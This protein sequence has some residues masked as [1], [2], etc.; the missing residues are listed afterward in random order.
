MKK[1]QEKETKIIVTAIGAY[2]TRVRSYLATISLN[3]ITRQAIQIFK[4]NAQ[5][6][7]LNVT[8]YN[9]AVADFN[10]RHGLLLLKRGAEQTQENA[11]DYNYINFPYLN[12]QGMKKAMD[13]YRK[14]VYQYNIEVTKQNKEI[15]KYNTTVVA[16][17]S[18]E[19][20]DNELKKITALQENPKGL[21]PREYNKAVA[22]LNTELQVNYIP[23]KRIQKVK[24]TSELV[25]NVLLGFYISQLQTRNNYLQGLGKSTRVHKNNVPKLKIDNRKLANH[26]ISGIPRLDLCKKTAQNHIKRL[27]EAGILINYEY[28]NQY[29]PITVHFNTAIVQILEGKFPKKQHPQNQ[30]FTTKCEKDLHDN[31]DSSIYLKRKE[32]KD[33][34]NFIVGDKCGSTTEA[35]VCPADGYKNTSRISTT[36]STG[37]QKDKNTMRKLLPDFLQTASEKNGTNAVLTRNFLAKITDD[38][39]LAKELTAGK[40]NQYTVLSYHYLRK[41]AQYANITTQE[42]RAV[43]IQDFIKSSAKIWKHHNSVYMGSWKKAID[44]LNGVLFDGLTQKET[45]IEKLKEYRFKLE[46][47]RKWFLK[48]NH[49]ALYPCLYFDVTRKCSSGIGFFG[50]H[51]VWLSHLKYQKKKAQEQQAKKRNENARIRKQNAK[52]RL[53]NAITAYKKGKYTAKQ[54]FHY[55]QDNLPH[56]YLLELTKA[57]EH[58][59]C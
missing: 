1:T 38:N 10:T 44:E 5:R 7:R 24:Y 58:K 12:R 53:S 59:Q 22:A 18:I 49:S 52:R 3:A 50:L 16:P 26:T 32:I 55:V 40:H 4:D 2:N 30:S 25:F 41:I 29:K 39:S 35:D 17:F 57:L 47:A 14:Y 23:K 20:G 43:L 28:V 34:E 33:Y 54:L 51:S 9:K 37:A 6:N 36:K 19:L 45:L 15:S 42:F 56:E 21:L 46:F 11:I 27:R 13:N 48:R 31:N 8:A